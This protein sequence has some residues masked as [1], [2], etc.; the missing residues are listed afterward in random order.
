MLRFENS[1]AECILLM[2]L[3]FGVRL[4]I[5]HFYIFTPRITETMII[6][7]CIQKSISIN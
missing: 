2:K 3:P 1:P 4:R 5:L 6:D 7:Y